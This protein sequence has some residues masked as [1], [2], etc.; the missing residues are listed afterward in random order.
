MPKKSVKSP[1]NITV[2]IKTP[3]PKKRTT[4]AKKIIKKEIVVTPPTPPQ[5]PKED[6]VVK[7]LIENSVVLQKALT[8]LS[9]RFDNLSNQISELLRLFEIA[10]KNIAEKPEL[11]FEKEFLDKLNSI[12][13]QNKLMARVITMIEERTRHGPEVAPT[14]TPAPAAPAPQYPPTPMPA[15]SEEYTPSGYQVEQGERKPKPLPQI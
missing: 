7:L 9:E 13:E 5:Q 6:P 2:N 14:P 8:H 12:L 4:R 11:G 1:A 3:T 15:P 10:A